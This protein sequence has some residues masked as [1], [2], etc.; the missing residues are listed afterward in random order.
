MIANDFGEFDISWNLDHNSRFQKNVSEN[1][2]SRP[3]A[4]QRPVVAG[5]QGVDPF[6]A[7]R[8]GPLGRGQNSLVIWGYS[9]Y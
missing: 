6:V 9:S 8:V 1:P 3:W 4:G 2:R 5:R 7:A